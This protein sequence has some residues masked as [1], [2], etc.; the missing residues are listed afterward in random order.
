MTNTE[1]ELGGVCHLALVCKDMQRTV[2]FYTNVLGMKLG[3][4][5]AIAKGGQHFF[6]DAGGGQFVAFF[7][8]PGAPERAP[9]IAS[10]TALPGVGDISTAHGSMNHV[11]FKIPVDKFEEYKAKLEAKG[12]VTA[13]ILNHDESERGWS[14]E[15]TETTFQRSMY[16]FDPDGILLEFAAW[17]RELR[18]SDVQHAPFDSDGVPAVT[19]HGA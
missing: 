2:D 11:S 1:F 16:F 8:F 10:P 3:M 9:G 19:G 4:T 12:V 18:D 17:T 6:F 7:W 5:M 15:I 14:L 13:P